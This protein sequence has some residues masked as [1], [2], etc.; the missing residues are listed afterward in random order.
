MILVDT[1]VLL[2]VLRDDQAW[3]EWSSKALASAAALDEVVINPV[4]YAELSSQYEEIRALDTAL[5]SLRIGYFEIPRTALFLAGHAFRRYRRAGGTR[6]GVLSDFFIGAH[7][8]VAAATL[9]TRDS[10]RVRSYFPTVA[11]IEP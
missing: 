11:V 10:G 4:I 1:N 9:L 3:R 7:A 8:A 5:D 2:D 6:A